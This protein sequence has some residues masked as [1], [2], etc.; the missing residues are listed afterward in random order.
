M[1]LNSTDNWN[2]Q[3]NTAGHISSSQGWR[4][5]TFVF[6]KATSQKNIWESLILLITK[7]T[8]KY[9]H[10]IMM[11]D[12]S[13]LVPPWNQSAQQRTWLHV[14]PWLDLHVEMVTAATHR[15]LFWKKIYFLMPTG[16]NFFLLFLKNRISASWFPDHHHALW[17][18]GRKS[19]DS[20][21]EKH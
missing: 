11:I 15:L 9:D 17:L 8:Q 1:L 4:G 6:A 20:S 13:V 16:W 10:D 3:T 5:K 14:L 19:L 7:Y 2:K 12:S 18:G 21:F